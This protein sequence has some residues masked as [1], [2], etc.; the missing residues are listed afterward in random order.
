MPGSLRLSRMSGESMP[1]FGSAGADFEAGLGAANALAAKVKG[2]IGTVL[3][4]AP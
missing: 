3:K 2:E 1:I 4:Q